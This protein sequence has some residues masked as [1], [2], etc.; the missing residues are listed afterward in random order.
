MLHILSCVMIAIV[1]KC[2]NMFAYKVHIRTICI[3][4]YLTCTIDQ[5]LSEGKTLQDQYDFTHKPYIIHMRYIHTPNTLVTCNIG[6][7][8]GVTAT[9]L[10]CELRT[11]EPLL[12]L[13]STT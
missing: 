6:F 10:M 9:V 11:L 5:I 2:I 4:Y 3:Y 7:D 1:C 12:T 8:E 13:E